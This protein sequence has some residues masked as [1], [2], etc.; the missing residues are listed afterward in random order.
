MAAA[1]IT[2]PTKPINGLYQAPITVK[3]TKATQND[4]VVLP[5]AGIL[6]ADAF[7]HTGA[8]DT[9]G[10]G[11]A[12]VNNTG[13]AYDADTTTIAI[14]GATTGRLAGN[15]YIE[16][17][18]GEWIYVV[19]DS[20]PTAAAANLTVRRGCLGTTA[21]ATGIANDNT[22]YIKN[23]LILSGATTGQVVLSYFSAP[24]DPGSTF[25]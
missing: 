3:L 1:K 22:M 10:F 13:D 20:A 12:V 17:T 25:F 5:E 6:G 14:D 8:Q 2:Y 19:K 9:V 21:S 23:I 4:W 16:T 7:L 18:S 15:Y 11:I 24:Q